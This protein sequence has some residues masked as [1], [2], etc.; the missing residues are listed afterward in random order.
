MKYNYSELEKECYD[1]VR[2]QC[3]AIMHM[4]EF[5][6]PESWADIYTYKADLLQQILDVYDDRE[7]VDHIT[8]DTTN[9]MD[10]HKR[11][12]RELSRTDIYDDN[13]EEI[14]Y[15]IIQS[16]IKYNDRH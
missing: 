7:E 3:R 2:E 9:I 14:D 4:G 12:Y 8:F 13:R 11:V 6:I 10:I 1:V 5:Y 16:M 15:L